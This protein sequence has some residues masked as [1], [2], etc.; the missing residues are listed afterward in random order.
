[1][2]GAGEVTIRDIIQT[3]GARVAYQL[4]A[5]RREVHLGLRTDSQL[6]FVINQ[7]IRHEIAEQLLAAR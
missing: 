5:V 2:N 6:Y 1:M 3:S 4:G 7:V